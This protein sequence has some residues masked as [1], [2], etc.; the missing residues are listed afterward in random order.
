MSSDFMRVKCQNCGHELTIFQRASTVVNC[1][2]CESI[3]VEPAGGKVNMV[4]CTL[5]EVL[6]SA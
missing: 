5:V 2:V 6:K 4:G 1:P 3:L